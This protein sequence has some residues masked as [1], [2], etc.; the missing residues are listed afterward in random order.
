MTARIAV[1]DYCKG[2]LSSVERALDAAGAEAFVTLDPEKIAAADAAVLPG[3]GSYADAM[4]YMRASG[5]AEAALEVIRA[6]RPFMG[7]CLGMQLLFDKGDEGAS[8]GGRWVE[9]L[10]VLPG[11]CAR[12]ES[13]RLK[14]PHVG[15][16]QIDL[17][18]AGRSCPLLDGVAD[19]ANFYFT[20]SYAVDASDGSC[21]MARTHYARSFTAVAARDNVFGTQFHPEKSSGKG[22]RILENFVGICE[23][24]LSW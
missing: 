7:I 21:V 16:N 2:N 4:G 3:V 12:L 8:A 11:S 17:T 15:W 22:M 23:G 14:V 24:R 1:I 9:G 19:G 13:A 5:E 10:G 6:G 20:H 18:P